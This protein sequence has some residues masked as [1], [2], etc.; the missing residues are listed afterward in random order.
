VPDALVDGQLHPRH[1]AQLYEAIAYLL[2]FIIGFILY[3]RMRD[4]VGKGFFFG[5]CMFAI[6]TFRFFVEFVKEVQVDFENNIPLDM[7]QLLSIPMLLIGAFFLWKGSRKEADKNVTAHAEILA[8]KSASEHIGNWRLDDCDLY[9]TLEPCPM[10]GWAILQSRIK[11]LYFGSY[12]NQYGA[13][14]VANLNKISESKTKIFSGICERDCD[15]II[16]NFFTQI[17]NNINLK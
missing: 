14:S 9:V 4:R 8:I 12:D 17:R 1:P 16:T 7:G 15:E 13:F 2:I 5:W 6:F 10:C 11:N 3:R